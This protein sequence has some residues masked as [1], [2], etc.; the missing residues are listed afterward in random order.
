MV[1][2]TKKSVSPLTLD[3]NTEGV[4]WTKR[5]VVPQVRFSHCGTKETHSITAGHETGYIRGPGVLQLPVVVSFTCRFLRRCRRILILEISS[6][7]SEH[8][9]EYF[10]VV[11]RRQEYD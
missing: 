1:L 5:R 11:A 7:V 10:E 9:P 6:S 3:F 2:R 8:N 4:E